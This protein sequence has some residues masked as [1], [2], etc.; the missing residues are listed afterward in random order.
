MRNGHFCIG[1]VS[2][3]VVSFVLMN[4]LF[5]LQIPFFLPSWFLFLVVQAWQLCWYH[6]QFHWN[7][8]I[9][10]SFHPQMIKDCMKKVVV[11]NLH[12]IIQVSFE[13]ILNYLQIF[14]SLEINIQNVLIERH[15]PLQYTTGFKEL[16]VLRLQKVVRY[17]PSLKF[18][19]IS[20]PHP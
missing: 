7:Y 17:K 4:S 9:N 11:V 15:R 16:Q 13:F 2:R 1:S 5:L 10:L 3:M 18:S 19:F 8:E 14:S 20:T 12:Q 6:S